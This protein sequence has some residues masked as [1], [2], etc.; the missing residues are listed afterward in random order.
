MTV[1]EVL[2]EFNKLRR[3]VYAYTPDGVKRIQVQMSRDAPTDS[4]IAWIKTDGSDKIIDPELNITVDGAEVPFIGNGNR[5]TIDGTAYELSNAS[6]IGLIDVTI[7]G[8]E[9]NPLDINNPVFDDTVPAETLPADDTSS[10]DTL[11]AT[12]DTI[13]SDTS[14]C[15]CPCSCNT[16]ASD[17]N[18]RIDEFINRLEGGA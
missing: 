11:P 9:D 6:E 5:I 2:D 17:I 4:N 1:L 7:S 16:G 3:Y 14:S 8:G 13:T 18:N 10:D 12:D 15:T